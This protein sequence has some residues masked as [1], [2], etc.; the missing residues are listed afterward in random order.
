MI[1]D[2]GLRLPAGQAGISKF[3]FTGP[4]VL[5]IA[6]LLPILIANCGLR[7]S[8]PSNGCSKDIRDGIT[9]SAVRFTLAD[10]VEFA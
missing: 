9:E 3:G 10:A 8:D 5:R 1:P 2:F 7:I 6:D 4:F